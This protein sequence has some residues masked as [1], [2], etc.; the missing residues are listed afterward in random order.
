[1]LWAHYLYQV[2]SFPHVTVWCAAPD[3]TFSHHI[4][5][6]K[7][8]WNDGAHEAYGAYGA[9][10]NKDICVPWMAY[11][12]HTD[13]HLLHHLCLVLFLLGSA[14]QGCKAPL[15]PHRVIH[16]LSKDRSITSQNCQQKNVTSMRL[17]LHRIWLKNLK[18][19]PKIGMFATK[20]IFAKLLSPTFNNHTSL[21]LNY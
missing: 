4:C 12:T 21:K 10:G 5:S 6:T 16:H 8:Q 14:D 11:S 1:M 7:H 9:G 13:R 20:N 17:N 19:L 2:A 18:T 15:V 3:Y